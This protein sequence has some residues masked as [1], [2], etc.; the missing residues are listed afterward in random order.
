[1]SDMHPP[2]RLFRSVGALFAAFVL[3]VVLS[4]GTDV[5]LHATGVMFNPRVSPTGPRSSYKRRRRRR[6]SPA[7]GA[8]DSFR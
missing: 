8:V 7:S 3:V 5:V 6:W 1:M 4:L 2:R